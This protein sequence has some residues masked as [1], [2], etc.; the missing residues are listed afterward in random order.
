[1][2]WAHTQRGAKNNITC[3]TVCT[4]RCA[5]GHIPVDD[6]AG[7][8]EEL[9]VC[10]RGVWDRLVT[11]DERGSRKAPFACRDNSAHD[12]NAIESHRKSQQ[13]KAPAAA[14][15]RPTRTFD[16][17]RSLW[18]HFGPATSLG[19]QI[20]NDVGCTEG[21]KT[22][23]GDTLLVYYTG[24]LAGSD[25]KFDNRHSQGSEPFKIK[26]GSARVIP[27]FEQ[28]LMGMCVG[29][30]R[31]VIVPPRL[32]YGG[33]DRPQIPPFSTLLFDI[34]LLGINQ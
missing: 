23:G 15:P 18:E 21:E 32:G 4:A 9:F 19:V 5:P 27:G 6:R 11:M 8:I 10:G 20:T 29:E 24:T 34:E 13:L 31:R 12:P 33:D 2:G 7:D 16:M 22:K 3:G 1:M 14:A 17:L 26:I 25:Y 28:G 30:T